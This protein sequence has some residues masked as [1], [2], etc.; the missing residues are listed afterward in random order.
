MS[1]RAKITCLFKGHAPVKQ[2]VVNVLSVVPGLSLGSKSEM[3]LVCDRC[4]KPLR[5][6]KAPDDDAVPYA[7][8]GDVTAVTSRGR[9]RD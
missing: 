5:S 2:I 3:W 7:T 8:W 4:R 9:H 1:M 6:T